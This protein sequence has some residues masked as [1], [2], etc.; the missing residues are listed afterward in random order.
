[1]PVGLRGYEQHQLDHIGIQLQWPEKLD[2]MFGALYDSE[3][4][5]GGPQHNGKYN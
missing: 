1:M 5:L 4:T 3:P 2:E